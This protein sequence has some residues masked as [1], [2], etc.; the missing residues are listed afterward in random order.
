MKNMISK[1]SVLAVVASM[2]L[3]AVAGTVT[4]KAE[5]AASP[6]QGSQFDIVSVAKINGT[7]E[8][9]LINSGL[10]D[11][12][13][14]DSD[15]SQSFAFGAAGLDPMNAESYSID[16]RLTGIALSTHVCGNSADAGSIQKLIGDIGRPGTCV[17]SGSADTVNASW[18][19]GYLVRASGGAVGKLTLSKRDGVDVSKADAPALAFLTSSMSSPGFTLDAMRMIN[20]GQIGS[21]ADQASDEITY[22]VSFDIRGS[23]SKKE[24]RAVFEHILQINP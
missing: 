14:T 16:P 1:L 4:L 2:S 5:N 8:V 22:A 21:L 3:S 20:D 12:V 10:S 13:L 24:S 11:L 18:K 6:A 17:V 15:G 7:L 19:V 23:M 9:D